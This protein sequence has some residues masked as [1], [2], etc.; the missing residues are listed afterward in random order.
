MK[1]NGD[2]PRCVR[3]LLPRSPRS[4]AQVLGFDENRANTLLV[5]D[6]KRPRTSPAP[7]FGRQAKIE[8]LETDQRSAW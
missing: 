4:V 5:A 3:R 1:A 6:G 7:S 2:M 8:A